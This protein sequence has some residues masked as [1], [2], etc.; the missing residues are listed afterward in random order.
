MASSSPNK[1]RIARSA[2]ILTTSEVAAS[3]LDLNEAFGSQV[4]VDASFTIGS[5]T[6]VILRFYASTDG[7]TWKPI[8]LGGIVVTETLTASAERAYVMPGLVGWKYFR[9]T[10]QGTGTV[11]SSSLT[12]TYRYLKR[13]SQF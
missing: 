1:Q 11:T 13:G 3:S 12:L 4:S 10:A 9:A 6:N 7:T 5:L 8:A 2:A